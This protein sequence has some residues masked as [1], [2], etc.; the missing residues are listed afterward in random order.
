LIEA[1]RR[2]GVK[3]GSGVDPVIPV[4][5]SQVAALAEML[6]AQRPHFMAVH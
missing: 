6:Y 4:K 1:N 5:P 2:T 3:D